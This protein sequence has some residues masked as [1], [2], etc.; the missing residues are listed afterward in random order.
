VKIPVAETIERMATMVLPLR[1][2]LIQNCH[3]GL[4]AE[5]QLILEEK[6]NPQLEVLSHKP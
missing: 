1:E 4:S 3:P 2:K 5:K 6:L